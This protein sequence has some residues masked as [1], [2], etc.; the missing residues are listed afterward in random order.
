MATRRIGLIDIRQAI[1]VQ[2]HFPMNALKIQQQL[3]T[4]RVNEEPAFAGLVLEHRIDAVGAILHSWIRR[5]TS[6][7]T[8]YVCQ[9]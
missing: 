6:K 3:F 7:L 8:E 5:G 1:T 9:P 2:I 4:A